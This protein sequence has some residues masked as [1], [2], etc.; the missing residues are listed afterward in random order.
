MDEN[1]INSI[2]KI[3]KFKI[4]SWVYIAFGLLIVIYPPKLKHLSYQGKFSFFTDVD[5]IDFYYFAYEVISYILIG[6]V[7]YFLFFKEGRNK[8]RQ[9]TLEEKESEALRNGG[10]W[11]R[12]TLRNLYM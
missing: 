3:D 9:M 12:S 4:F 5:Q 1:I 7:I 2:K 6:S 10:V 8:K 11:D